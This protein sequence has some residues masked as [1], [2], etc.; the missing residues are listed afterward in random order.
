MIRSRRKLV[1]GLLSLVAFLTAGSG[2]LLVRHP[3]SH[4]DALPGQSV[5]GGALDHAGHG[6]APDAGDSEHEDGAAC[7]CLG[8]CAT[9]SEAPA[10]PAKPIA[11]LRAPDATPSTRAS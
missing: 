5:A 10:G 4:H 2:D 6:A 11:H 7:T 9:G 8:S 1:L 3:C